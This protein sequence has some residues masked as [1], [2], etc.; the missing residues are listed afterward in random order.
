[1]KYIGLL[2]YPLSH[3]ISP[4]FQQAAIDYYKLDIIYQAWEKAPTELREVMEKARAA[5]CLGMNVTI[6][7]KRAVLPYMDELDKTVDEI[8][9]VNTIIN[10]KGKLKGYNTDAPGFLK[11]LLQDGD[12]NPRGKKAVILGCGG[13]GRAVAFALCWEGISE[14]LFFNRT[15]DKAR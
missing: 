15:S 9:A 14:I 13:A 4:Y 6:P 5:S 3:S 10:Q 7:Y 8:K 2:G 1:M 12:F 11:A